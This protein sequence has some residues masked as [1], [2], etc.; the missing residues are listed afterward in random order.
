MSPNLL[1]SCYPRQLE[2]KCLF[3][4]LKPVK[5]IVLS[6]QLLVPANVTVHS[7]VIQRRGRIL[8]YKPICV[9]VS[10][11]IIVRFRLL[12]NVEWFAL[13]EHNA[14]TVCVCLY[15]MC[16]TNEFVSCEKWQLVNKS[17]RCRSMSSRL[18]AVF[19]CWRWQVWWCTVLWSN[20]VAQ[21]VN[22][23]RSVHL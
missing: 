8:Q 12:S 10:V 23:G 20:G 22:P 6:V 19:N 7:T 3:V 18:H 17:V 4:C 5:P 2:S 9:S 15:N 11:E 1:L 13:L 21:S 16:C 14:F